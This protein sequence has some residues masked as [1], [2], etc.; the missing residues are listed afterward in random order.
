M[1][2]QKAGFENLDGFLLPTDMIIEVT[3]KVDYSLIKSSLS[4]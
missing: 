4:N 2:D 3:F 1:A